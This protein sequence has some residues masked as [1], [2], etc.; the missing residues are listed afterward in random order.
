MSIHR[1]SNHRHH[2][3][4]GQHQVSASHSLHYLQLLTLI[5]DFRLS[6]LPRHI[7]T[8][9]QA[10]HD[11]YRIDSSSATYL[12]LES[13]QRLTLSTSHCQPATRAQTL[14][15]PPTTLSTLFSLLS[16]SLSFGHFFCHS[17]S[18]T[19]LPSF[20]S[21]VSFSHALSILIDGSRVGLDGRMVW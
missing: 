18:V 21:V 20:P 10:R 9:P 19:F 1:N 5:L 11:T 12:G 2:R 6:S 16:N 4:V 17:P 13:R 15:Q 8:L 3:V 7:G 14:Q